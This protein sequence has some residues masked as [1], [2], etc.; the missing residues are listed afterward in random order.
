MSAQIASTLDLIRNEISKNPTLKKLSDRFE[1]TTKISSENVV[2]GIAI[3]ALFMLFSGYG[4]GI[5]CHIA[6]FAYPFYGTILTL[7][8]SKKGPMSQFWLVYWIVY[9]FLG[10]AETFLAVILKQVLLYY[11]FKLLFCLWL[12]LPYFKGADIVYSKVIV[13]LFKRHETA[14]DEAL[15]KV[16]KAITKDN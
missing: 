12:Y 8:Q 13:P 6:S 1:E 4:A 7:S 2:L 16:D 10:V 15:R 9:G 11:P 14:I 5:V 3:V